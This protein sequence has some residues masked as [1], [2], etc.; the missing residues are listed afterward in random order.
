MD[1]PPLVRRCETARDLDRVLDRLARMS[2]QRGEPPTQ[3]VPFE[4]L[5]DDEGTRLMRAQSYTAVMFGWLRAPAARA[6]CSKRRRRS[7]SAAT[8][9][10]AP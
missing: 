2:R 8:G 9:A 7:V 6:S 3:R 1:D 5:R 10:A 4:Q